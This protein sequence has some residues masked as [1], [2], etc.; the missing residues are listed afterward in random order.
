MDQGDAGAVPRSSQSGTGKATIR[1]N[2]GCGRSPTPDWHNYD[3]S[4][5]IRLARVPFDLAWL[6]R[7][8]L[9]SQ[10]QSAFIAFARGYEIQW[11]DATRRI[12]EVDNSVEVAYS[13]HMVEHLNARQ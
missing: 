3:N 1:V 7:L 6:Q 4:P 5:S 8:G 11:A 12:P 2:I 10:T 9:L 13:C